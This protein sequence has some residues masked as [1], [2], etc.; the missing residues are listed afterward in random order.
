MK[1]IQE[2]RF[3][4]IQKELDHIES[5]IR[6]IDDIANSIKNW[7]IV[8][9]GGSIALLLKEPGFQK[10]LLITAVLP[11]AFLLV[12]ARWRKVQR[13]FIYRLNVIGRFLNRD[14]IDQRLC[15]PLGDE[16]VLL[17]PRAK[18]SHGEDYDDFVSIKKVLKFRTVSWLY[19]GMVA[20]SIM[21]GVIALV[22]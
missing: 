20:M 7:A 14:D 13:S 22:K 19:I 17:D 15:K 8:T 2:I 18:L 9:W 3:E 12:D 16:F 4:T 21:I 5:A 10:F 1:E 11:I 6:K